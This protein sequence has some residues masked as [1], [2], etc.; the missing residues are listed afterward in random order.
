MSINISLTPQLESLVKN[1]V[2]TG[3]YKSAS[4]VI[5]EALRLME[6]VSTLRKNS[7]DDLQTKITNPLSS[8]YSKEEIELISSSLPHADFYTQEINDL[9]EFH[10]LAEKSF[11]FW[12]NKN[13]DIY[14]TCDA[15]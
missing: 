7:F 4:E 13:D 1:K 3:L 2:K 6:Q 8:P 5:R 9:K 14:S 12:E 10:S 15:I 11:S